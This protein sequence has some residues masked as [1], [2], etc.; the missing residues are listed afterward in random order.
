MD[1]LYTGKGFTLEL[2]SVLFA[3]RL[4]LLSK[5]GMAIF[6]KEKKKKKKTGKDGLWKRFLEFFGGIA[7]FGE[8]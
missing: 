1:A 8:Q 2:V 7:T 4:L 3:P 5:N 6:E